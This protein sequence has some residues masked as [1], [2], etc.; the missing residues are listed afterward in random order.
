MTD[1]EVTAQSVFPVIADPTWC[2]ITVGDVNADGVDDLI[3]FHGETRSVVVWHMMLEGDLL[4]IDTARFITGGVLPEA[5][6]GFRWAVKV[7]QHPS[8]RLLWQLEEIK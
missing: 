7:L 1:F 4:V 3:W 5:P 6:A 2:I 8:L